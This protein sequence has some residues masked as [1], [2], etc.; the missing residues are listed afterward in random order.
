MPEKHY[1]WHTAFQKRRLARAVLIR[2]LERYCQQATPPLELNYHF[3]S[4][5]SSDFVEYTK[6]HP[7]RLFFMSDGQAASICDSMAT[8]SALCSKS[9][10]HRELSIMTFNSVIFGLT[11]SGYTVG[12]LDDIEFKSSELWGPARPLPMGLDIDEALVKSY[13]G[14]DV[15]NNKILT[16]RERTA[17]VA[18][19]ALLAKD[20]SQEMKQRADAF[21]VH[22]AILKH[23]PLSLRPT[24]LRS[25]DEKPDIEAISHQDTSGKE[26]QMSLH[27]QEFL[28]PFSQPDFDSLLQ[29]IV[30]KTSLSRTEPASTFGS[31]LFKDDSHWHSTKKINALP[32]TVPIT[33]FEEKKRLK[34]RQQQVARIHNYAASLTNAVGKAL[35]SETII[36]SKP[37]EP[38][39]GP[40]VPKDKRRM[41]EIPCR[42][43]KAPDAQQDEAN[44][45]WRRAFAKFQEEPDA[46]KR[47]N[48]VS[49]F[50]K[51][52]RS[53]LWR[54]AVGPDAILYACCTLAKQVLTNDESLQ[55]IVPELK[56][57]AWRHFQDLQEI[58]LS[59]SMSQAAKKLSDSFGL[60]M[61][62]APSGDEITQC[63]LSENLFMATLTSLGR[64]KS[65]RR[66]NETAM[67]LDTCGPY[68]EKGFDSR[69]DSRVSSFDPDAWQRDVLDVIDQRE[70]LFVVAPTSAG[71]TFISFYAMKQV[72]KESDDG[73]LAYVAPTKALSN[74]VAADIQARFN[75]NYPPKMVGKSVWAIHT[76]DY[77]I[78]TSTNCQILVTVPQMLQILLLAPSSST[79]IGTGTGKNSWTSRIK[80]IIFDEVHSIGLSE[81]GVVWEQLLLMA[82]CPII[83]LSATVGNPHEFRAW[84]EDLSALVDRSRDT[85]DDINIESRD[86][87]TLWKSMNKHQSAKYP[88]DPNLNPDAFFSGLSIVKAKVVAWEAE[89]KKVLLAWLRN[90]DSPFLDVQKEISPPLDQEAPHRQYGVDQTLQL[91]VDLQKRDALPA[92]VF[93]YDRDGCKLSVQK[94]VKK[95]RE[96]ET[97]WK[98]TSPEWK[99][100]RD[101]FEKYK[102]GTKQG[103]KKAPKAS[104]KSKRGKHDDDDDDGPSSKLDSIRENSSKEASKWD[105]F[106]PDAPLDRFSFANYKKLQKSE[107][108]EYIKSLERVR[109]EDYII[110]GL[111]RGVAVHHSGM[112]RGY[113][114]TVEILFRKGF[115]TAVVAT[116]TLA[117]GINMPC[118]TVVFSGDSTFLTALNFRQGAGRA[119]RRGFDILGNVVF[120]D[121]TP[122]RAKEVMSLRLSDLRGH[123]PISTSLVL[124]V[125]TLLHQTNRCAFS[126]QVLRALFSQTRI[127]Q[128]GPEGKGAI[129]HHLRF[130][131]EYLRHHNL[132]SADG[133]P[134][135]FSGLV[136]HLHY[137]EDAVFALHSLLEAG[138]FHRLCAD[139]HCKE[140]EVLDTMVLVLSHLFGRILCRRY[141]D[142]EW[143]QTKVYRSSSKVLLPRLPGDAEMVLHEHN[144]GTLSIFQS[145][146]QTYVRQHLSDQPDDT[147]PFTSQKVAPII[148]S[149][150]PPLI[151]S[152]APVELRSPFAALSGFTDD[153]HSVRE[154]CSTVRAGV[155]LEE[156]SVPYLTISP[157]DTDGMPFNAYIY[158]FFRHGE[159]KT[160]EDA[161]GIKNSDAWYLLNDFALVLKTIVASLAKFLG[162]SAVAGDDFELDGVSDDAAGFDDEA[163]FG[164]ANYAAAEVAPLPALSQPLASVGKRMAASAAPAAKKKKEKVLDSWEDAS[165]ESDGEGD[166]GAGNDEN[167]ETDENGV[168]KPGPVVPQAETCKPISSSPEQGL[169]AVFVAFEKLEKQF[170]QKFHKIWA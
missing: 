102:K 88:L 100:T 57:L 70:S 110:E 86:C 62:F 60:S 76:R 26:L 11:S 111:R 142:A 37:D 39:K 19:A 132:L 84:V 7:V 96:F 92:L 85:L 54:H 16:S 112:N 133:A 107:L 136:S 95:L 18:L 117:L 122:Q 123:F 44:T 164:G 119:G 94:I 56:A 82:P 41:R 140:N 3:S 134:I 47:Y 103:Q 163:G 46:L 144:A 150:G 49:N 105:S 160:I 35:E 31:K 81:E 51:Q 34:K 165:S 158:D 99:R 5:G 143:L 50:L 68:M 40:K 139:I 55:T 156:S 155:F 15:I 147:L 65:L 87:L 153:F 59:S 116:G 91:L 162:P 115:L 6:Q 169:A 21:I 27:G 135:D 64:D 154:L 161:N 67:V 52:K 74:Q 75:K 109:L 146:V 120:Y 113:L 118:K 131:I 138:Y 121:F 43:E 53:L 98:A 10:P 97:L 106:D 61:D 38:S 152:R 125:A 128:G 127:Y 14:L 78:N 23:R 149:T 66:S 29:D 73:V 108:E 129:K 166:D 157:A 89:L 36:T 83:A 168:R 145:Y 12:I 32:G 124:R 63:F 42:G 79:D 4:M 45:E 126:Q 58:S 90:H 77:R 71:K 80:W 20:Q 17:V 22:L 93:L 159:L 167:D 151:A 8:D 2:H 141:N 28:L 69:P 114:Q 72:L 104:K 137:S 13:M 9:I 33:P 170:D 48:L 1:A 30:V 130:S 101:A 24:A 25:G 148:P